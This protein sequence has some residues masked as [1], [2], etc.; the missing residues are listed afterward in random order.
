MRDFRRVAVCATGLSLLISTCACA[1]ALGNKSSYRLDKMPV[2]YSVL[3]KVRTRYVNPRRIEP[4]R[5]LFEALDSMERR[6]PE[7]LIEP[8]DRKQ[9]RRIRVQ[10]G[11]QSRWFDVSRVRSPWDLTA[12]LGSIF[13]FVGPRLHRDTDP[14]QVEFAAVDGILSTLDP[15]TIL[16]RPEFFRELE[17]DTSGHFGGLGIEISVCDGH[18]TIRRPLPGT[19]AWKTRMKYG[20]G[21]YRTSPPDQ[22]AKLVRSKG[23][24]RWQRLNPTD[25]RLSVHRGDEVIRLRAGDRIVRIQDESTV[26][27]TLSESVKRLRGRP[28]TDVLVWILRKGWR[29]PKPFLIRRA[30]V[31]VRS[32]TYQDLGH[33]VGYVR[34]SKFSST[35]GAELRQALAAHSRLAG[36]IIDLRDNHGG[37]LDQAAAVM[38][39]F[40]QSGTLLAAKEAGRI[41]P[42]RA[43]RATTLAP[44]LPLVV[45]TN[46]ETA[47]AAEIVAAGLKQLNRAVVVGRRTFGKG[48]VQMIFRTP[49]HTALKLTISQ[50]L[51]PG[52]L[53][54]QGKG[55]VPDVAAVPVRA[56]KGKPIEYL[57]QPL[58]FRK[59]KDLKRPLSVPTAE[60][61]SKPLATVR[62]LK[63]P[64]PAKARAIPCRYCGQPKDTEP[65]RDPSV[66]YK[67]FPVFLAERILREAGRP[68]RLAMLAAATDTLTAVS[69]SEDEAITKQLAA[70]GIIWSKAP[71]GTKSPTGLRVRLVPDKIRILAGS[72]IT[73]RAKAVNPTPQTAYRVRAQL[74]STNPFVKGR[75]LLFGTVPPSGTRSAAVTLRIPPSLRRQRDRVLVRLFVDET[76]PSGS[77][78]GTV[79]LQGRPR[80]A[81]AFSFGLAEGAGADEDG[82]LETGETILVHMTVTN[83]GRGAAQEAYAVLENQSGSALDVGSGRFPISGLKPRASKKVTFHFKLLKVPRSGVVR[84]RLRV[85]DCVMGTT[86]SKKVSLRVWPSGTNPVRLRRMVLVSNK[87]VPIRFC[88]DS[89]CSEMAV[90]PA[91]SPLTARGKIGHWYLVEL[92]GSQ[93]GFVEAGSLR[94]LK[95]H[96][97]RRMSIQTRT[98]I[99]PPKIAIKSVPLE[100]KTG[101]VVLRGFATHPTAVADLF[102]RV[103]N[104]KEKIFERKAAYLSNRRGKDPKQVNFS[105][106]V[107]LWPGKNIVEVVARHDDEIQTT[108]QRVIL[109]PA[110]KGRSEADGDGS[111][112]R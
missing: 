90:A 27:M 18:L 65:P 66:F 74:D 26:N 47:S 77:T 48:S 112:R 60:L 61:R 72:K 56:Q 110:T 17:I 12:V 81:F 86:L 9:V 50:W 71:K 16:M 85:Y 53:S 10:V 52:N 42:I 37:L 109:V 57:S 67:D 33:H 29:R 49:F 76:R 83:Q 111:E 34:I 44:K 19:P 6:V 4:K 105:V 21:I 80:P 101:F 91:R 13:R 54:I 63:R 89:T 40:V 28:R 51:A 3:D 20:R 43:R 96:P 68:R 5:M 106:R 41:R 46:E 93:K 38:D 79:T 36:L 84:L 99:V 70:L 94:V 102:V 100:T 87:A 75:E 8:L 103:S 64:V 98:A 69:K 82:L 58:R 32:V 22:A 88:P 108:V 107:P 92:K 31:H 15:H 25:P 7:I 73:I 14:K 11:A 24:W 35:T 23:T 1:T 45:L 62:Y 39:L 30:V 104:P 78:T 59:E 55:L 95:G 97:L 2:L